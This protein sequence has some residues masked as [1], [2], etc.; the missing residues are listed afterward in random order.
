MVSFPGDVSPDFE[1]WHDLLRAIIPYQQLSHQ[2]ALSLNPAIW[3]I[4]AETILHCGKKGLP[5]HSQISTALGEYCDT[6][7]V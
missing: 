7:V 1:E 5:I 4:H 3:R 2:D 6:A